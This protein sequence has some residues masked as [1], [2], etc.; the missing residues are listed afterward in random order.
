VYI[1]DSFCK[2]LEDDF[3]FK[4]HVKGYFSDFNDVPDDLDIM[5]S[6]GGD[7]TVLETV[8]IIRDKGIPIAGINSGRLGFLANISKTQLEKAVKTILN[9]NFTVE[10]RALLQLKSNRDIFSDFNIALNEITVHKKDTSSMI[11]I[12]TIVNGELLT[13]YW[14]DGLIVS[15]P[16]GSTAYSLSV[17][18]PIVVPQSKNI[19]ISPIAPHNLTMRPIVLPDDVDIKLRMHGRDNSFLVSLDYRSEDFDGNDELI[20]RRAKYDIQMVKLPDTSF[21]KTIR[22]KMMWGLDKRNRN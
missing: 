17:G 21:Y 10:N 12:D 1:F 15:T 16:T 2:F 22:A 5:F 20:I 6:I 13:T 11:A 4:P 7:G 9:G 19:I 3:D 8:S 18:G 14:A